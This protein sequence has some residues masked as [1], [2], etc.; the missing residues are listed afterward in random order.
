MPVGMSSVVPGS[1]TRGASKQA[2]KSMPADPAVACCG[3][4]NSR[5]MRGSKIRSLI[6]GCISAPRAAG[7]HAIARQGGGRAALTRT[8]SRTAVGGRQAA[9]DQGDELARN[10]DFRSARD[11]DLAAGPDDGERIVLAIERNAVAHLVGGDHVEFLALELAARV[12]LDVVGFG[13][14]SDDEGTLGHVRD[15]LDDVGR[16]LEVELHRDALLFY[17]A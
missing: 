11:F 5:P 13:G 3:S 10:V 9:R 2:R 6:L 8:A 12:V 15:R 4:G 14:K 1:N 7:A 16:G 17:L